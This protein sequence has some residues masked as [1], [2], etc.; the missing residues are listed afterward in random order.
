M[1]DNAFHCV[2]WKKGFHEDFT[3]SIIHREVEETRWDRSHFHHCSLMFDSFRWV[4]QTSC[5]DFSCLSAWK[6]TAAGHFV[7]ATWTLRVLLL[8][9]TT[10]AYKILLF[11]RVSACSL[12][13]F[14]KINYVKLSCYARKS[15][16]LCSAVI[17]LEA[18]Q[19]ALMFSNRFSQI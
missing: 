6:Q 3:L 9:R 4:S 7:S 2:N 12:A 5:W 1:L 11:V 17:M 19:K 10:H 14:V 18:A 15:N 16:R 8:R 13:G